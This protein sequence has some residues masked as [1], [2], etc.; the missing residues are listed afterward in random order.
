MGVVAQSLPWR[1]KQTQFFRPEIDKNRVIRKM[2]DWGNSNTSDWIQ[3]QVPP[4]RRRRSPPCRIAADLRRNAH[5]QCSL[6]Q[7]KAQWSR[8]RCSNERST[9]VSPIN[10]D[11]LQ[12]HFQKSLFCLIRSKNLVK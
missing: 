2:S 5:H 12:H 11:L 6:A 9:P 3:P 1:R 10:T 7:R 4:S 8:R